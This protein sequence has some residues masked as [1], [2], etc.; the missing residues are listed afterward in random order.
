MPRAPRVFDLP[1]DPVMQVVCGRDAGRAAEAAHRLGWAE[2]DT[3][4]HRVVER[5]DIGLIEVGLA[6]GD[7]RSSAA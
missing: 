7:L 3:D 1:L 5:A 2:S 4:W 6:T